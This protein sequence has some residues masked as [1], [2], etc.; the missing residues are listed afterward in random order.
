MKYDEYGE[1]INEAETYKHIALLLETGSVVI[2]W[3]DGQGTHL[4]IL[5]C[6]RPYE[7]GSLQG[8]Q[9]ASTD[10]FVAVLKRGA[11]GFEI[12]N[13][14]THAGYIEGK[15]GGGLG[16]TADKLAELINQ[17]KKAIAEG[18]AGALNKTGEYGD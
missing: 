9:S 10:L 6:L 18:E 16:S 8:G 12:K 3:S 15:L 13:E 11:F 1:V 14:D 4:D 7:Y 2:G 17:I 5:F